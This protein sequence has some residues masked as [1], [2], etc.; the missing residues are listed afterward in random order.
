MP[1]DKRKT[2]KLYDAVAPAYSFFRRRTISKDTQTMPMIMDAL[3][4]EDGEHILDA[5]TG[6]GVYAME[7]AACVPGAQVVGVDLSP[8]FVEIAREAAG[9]LGVANIKFHV[10]DLEDLEFP[11]G[12]FD[13]VV[14]AGAIS[15]V[16]D[17]ERAARELHRVLRREGLAVISEPHRERSLKDRAW[18]GAMIAMGWMIPKMRGLRASHWD[19]YYF[20]EQEFE[21]LFRNAGFSDVRIEEPGTDICAICRK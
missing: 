10:G 5:G 14:C 3:S 18:L 11:D 17:K 8:K 15:A 1:V 20:D 6:P 2:Q 4:P 12:S 21:G 19:S 13:K 9:K 7:I 16:P